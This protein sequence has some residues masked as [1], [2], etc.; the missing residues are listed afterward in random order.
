MMTK[1][2]MKKFKLLSKNGL[3]FSTIFALSSCTS[4][5]EQSINKIN[6]NFKNKPLKTLEKLD[7]LYSKIKTKEEK[8]LVL[9]EIE[10]IIKTGVRDPQLLKHV[11]EK[12][13]F[14]TDHLETKNKILL[15]LAQLSVQNLR[16][17]ELAQE[18]LFKVQEK[19][20]NSEERAQYFQLRIISYINAG[21]MTQAGIEIEDLLAREDLTPTER[22]KIEILKTRVL[23]SLEK[24]DDM[25]KVFLKLLASYPNLSKK[26]RVRSQLSLMYEE[27]DNFDE[28]LKHLKILQKEDP[29][30][31]MIEIRIEQLTKRSRQ[32]PGGQGRLRR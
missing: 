29:K 5:L 15:D 14:F 13:V 25:E 11:L 3:L 28:A 16:D 18:Y 26:W 22:F 12:K 23:S 21:E 9:S 2:E 1:A 24:Y 6:Q 7:D 17:N 10:K 19:S 30:D 20:L 32:Q 4:D 31:E 8:L 27:Q